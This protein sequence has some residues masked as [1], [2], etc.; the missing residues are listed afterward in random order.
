MNKK[1]N[2]FSIFLFLIGFTIC[3]WPVIS[4]I[5]QHYEQQQVIQTYQSTLQKKNRKDILKEIKKAQSY[6]YELAHAQVHNLPFSQ[7]T[8]RYHSLL[9]MQ[10]TGIMGS[11][12]IPSIRVNLPIYHGVDDAVLSIGAGHLSSSSLP[13][14]G[15]HTHCVLT[16]HR[17]LVNAKLFTRLDELKTG[18]MV[19][20]KVW[21]QILAYKVVDSFVV[22][23]QDI[24]KL[25][26]KKG[27]DLLSLVTCTPYGLNTHRLILRAKRVPYARESEKLV[28]HNH[29]PFKEFLF[30]LAPWAFLALH[31]GSYQKRYKRHYILLLIT[32][33]FCDP[34]VIKA[35]D[36]II[37]V[38]TG[39][40]GALYRYWTM[41]GIT[42]MLSAFLQY[43][44]RHL[45]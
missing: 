2:F 13:V 38:P 41:V 28:K 26:I 6:N 23:P 11:I 18:D 42:F 37:S 30:L 36:D 12:E 27:E 34:V 8:K 17:G 10:K 7:S 24:S 1:L 4:R 29:L 3:V 32:L 20:L 16:S 19:Y 45:K 14:G 35:R 22:D 9:N 31:L 44:K 15:A 39:D 33:L 43:K 21:N 40:D 5:V 25:V